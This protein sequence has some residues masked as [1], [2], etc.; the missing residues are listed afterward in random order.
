MTTKHPTRPLRLA[1]LGLF[2]ALFAGASAA[3]AAEVEVSIVKIKA[4][5][6]PTGAPEIDEAIADLPAIAGLCR[7]YAK[8][9]HEGTTRKKVDWGA[10]VTSGSGAARIAVTAKAPKKDGGKIPIAVAIGPEG[11][12]C[13]SN[14]S[15]V[16]AGAPLVRFC[17]KTLP[18]GTYIFV[19]TAKPL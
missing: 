2:A 7:M 9:T 11:A 10:Q 4:V 3:S 17:E 14:A 8:C 15:S 6:S 12:P 13:L 19:V 5:G 1:L 16:K 18:D